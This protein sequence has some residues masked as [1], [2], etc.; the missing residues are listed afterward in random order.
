MPELTDEQ[1]PDERRSRRFSKAFAA[2]ASE[3]DLAELDIN[4]DEVFADVRDDVSSENS[5]AT[6]R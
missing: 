1:Q 2:F 5:I 6:W 3:V 4:P